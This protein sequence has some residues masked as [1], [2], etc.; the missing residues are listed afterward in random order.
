MELAI[1]IDIEGFSIK[2]ENGG[3]QSY[4]DLTNDLYAL[5]CSQFKY[6]SIIQFG[7][8]GVLIKENIFYTNDLRKFIEISVGLLQIIALRGG[9]GR[10][11]ISSGEMA[12]ISGLYNAK[13]RNELA[14][15]KILLS[16]HRNIMMVNSVIGTAIIKSYKLK[17]PK[18]ALL[19]IDK[20]L[21]SEEDKEKYIHYNSDDYEVYGINWIKYES[22]M[23]FEML[24][25]LSLNSKDLTAKINSYLKE[26][27]PSDEWTRETEKLVS[28]CN[29]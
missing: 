17:G 29:F 1:Y 7:G 2:F 6:L 3:K 19:L 22:E 8:D 18:G 9:I 16:E 10:V 11:Q 20:S 24:K 15:G 14:L 21:I 12:D 13:I 27:K 25:T 4:I 23:T 28:E 26:N 5:G